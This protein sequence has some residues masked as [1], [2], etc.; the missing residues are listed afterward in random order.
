MSLDRDRAFAEGGI[1]ICKQ[2]ISSNI[3]CTCFCLSWVLFK[4]IHFLCCYFF[5]IFISLMYLEKLTFITLKR[6]IL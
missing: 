5:F 3:S 1:I 6:F 4:C 2:G